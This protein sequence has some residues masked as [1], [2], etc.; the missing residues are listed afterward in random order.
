MAGK[1]IEMD[2]DIVRRKEDIRILLRIQ[3]VM[4]GLGYDNPTK[5]LSENI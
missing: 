5:Y 3:V 4:I 1:R 2:G